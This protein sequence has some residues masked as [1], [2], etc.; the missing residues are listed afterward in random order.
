MRTTAISV[1]A[2]V[3]GCAD[4][5][6]SSVDYDRLAPIIG[7]SIA[8]ADTG[9]EVGALADAVMIARGGL[10]RGADAN[11]GFV[12][13]LH[14]GVR[15]AYAVFCQDARGAA[16]TCSP[17]TFRAYAFVQWDAAAMHRSGMWELEHL[18][19]TSATATGTSD[20]THLAGDYRI[21]DLRQETFTVD[22]AT[23]QPSRVRIDAAL[24]VTSDGTPTPVTASV[25]LDHGRVALLVL[26][27][28]GYSLDLATGTVGPVIIE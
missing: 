16:T 11:G 28:T 1:L 19:G 12:A 14:D 22:L 15:Y 8:T 25:S 7:S 2:L 13:G 6:S 10:P 20:L 17:H 9:G 3:G 23:Y 4:S 27:G 5:A 21:A 24:R 26:D 18:Q